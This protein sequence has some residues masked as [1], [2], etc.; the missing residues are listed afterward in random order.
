MY[1]ART[2]ASIFGSVA[3]CGCVPLG[4][5][6]CV[7]DFVAVNQGEN[8]GP[9]VNS[10]RVAATV[11]RGRSGGIGVSRRL[12]SSASRRIL[13]DGAADGRARDAHESATTFTGAPGC[14]AGETAGLLH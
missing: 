12:G 8:E 2:V 1:H 14:D 13:E 6:S 11:A 7:S 9:I 10:L 3:I 4:A 5:C